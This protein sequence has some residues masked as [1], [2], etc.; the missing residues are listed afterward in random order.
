MACAETGTSEKRELEVE[1][2]KSRP[3]PSELDRR[4]GHES[5][6]WPIVLLT[7]VQAVFAGN[8][9]LSK[10]MMNNGVSPIVFCFLRDFFGS[11][12]LIGLAR[13]P[14]GVWQSPGSKADYIMLALCGFVGVCGAQVLMVVAIQYLSPATATLFQLLIPVV[15]PFV[16]AAAGLEPLIDARWQKT[17]YRFTGLLL[18]IL[19]AAFDIVSKQTLGGSFAGF[20]ILFLQ[21]LSSACYQILTKQALRKKWHPLPLVAWTYISGTLMLFVFA[22]PFTPADA[23]LSLDRWVALTVVY[24]VIFT[25]TFCYVANATVN[26]WLGPTVVTAFFPL[27]P[28]LTSLAAPWAGLGAVSMVDVQSAAIVFLGL[29]CFLSGERLPAVQNQG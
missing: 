14:F 15:T 8:A 23:W 27:Q 11:C 29:S 25:S 22:L 17:F 13:S 6:F 1:G 4:G 16:A 21:V 28:L 26:R 3:T 2:I 9:L 19:G 12:C 7:A 24:A 20:I 10:K 5:L 18:C